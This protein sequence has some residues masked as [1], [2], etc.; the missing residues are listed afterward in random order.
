MQRMGR[1]LGLVVIMGISVVTAEVGAFRA[2]RA[3]TPMVNIGTF[4][5]HLSPFVDL[6]ALEVYAVAGA[7]GYFFDV[8]WEAQDENGNNIYQIHGGGA[9]G[10]HTDGTH[11]VGITFEALNDTDLFDLAPSLTVHMAFRVSDQV[12]GW[13]MQSLGDTD[14]FNAAGPLVPFTCGEPPSARLI[15]MRAQGAIAL[16]HQA[17][18]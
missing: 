3:M 5:F 6:L 4:C 12:G 18:K 13:R 11:V 9:A 17:Q 15:Q 10:G 2:P 16:G 8:H 1:L 14:L 7:P